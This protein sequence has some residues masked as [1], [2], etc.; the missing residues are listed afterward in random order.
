M[1]LND[2]FFFGFCFTLFQMT[3]KYALSNDVNKFCNITSV[4]LVAR[5]DSVLKEILPLRGVG[6]GGD[7]NLLYMA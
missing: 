6:S 5:R 2:F 1:P 3:S 4:T 7:D